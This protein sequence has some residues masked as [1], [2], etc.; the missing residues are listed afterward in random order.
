MPFQYSDFRI[1]I[2]D[3][4][5][6]L[7]VR[8]IPRPKPRQTRKDKFDPSKSVQDYRFWADKVRLAWTQSF[9]DEPWPGAIMLSAV[10]EFPIPGRWNKRERELALSGSLSHT[11]PPDLDNLFKG[12]VDERLSIRWLYVSVGF[13]CQPGQFQL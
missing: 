7:R 8:G 10:F 5:Q 4:R 3:T 9:K 11:S 13:R 6:M 1:P 2:T 12:V